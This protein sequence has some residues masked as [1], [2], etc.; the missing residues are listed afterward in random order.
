MIFLQATLLWSIRGAH[1]AATQKYPTG[2]EFRPPYALELLPRGLA[3]P[4]KLHQK[5]LIDPGKQDAYNVF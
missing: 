5:P 2:A 4:Y 1:P 3:T